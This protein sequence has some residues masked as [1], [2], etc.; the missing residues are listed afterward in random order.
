[1]SFEVASRGVSSRSTSARGVSRHPQERTE[2]PRVGS[3]ILPL[4]MLKSD[5]ELTH[6]NAHQ[7]W[8]AFVRI[9]PLLHAVAKV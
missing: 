4:A 2:N 7:K 9:D 3:S 6:L 1:M 8:W 5:N